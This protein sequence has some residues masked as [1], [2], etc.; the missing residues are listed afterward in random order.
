M[1]KY[2][3]IKKINYDAKHIYIETT[4]EVYKAE[5]IDGVVG[6]NIYD[7]NNKQLYLTN[8]NIDDKIKIYYKNNI[9]KKIIM[10][11]KYELN[12]DSE[13]SDDI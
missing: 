5:I 2:I 9:I 7:V 1:E 12:S 4:T 10:E 3:V 13:L 11:T 8:L 6:F